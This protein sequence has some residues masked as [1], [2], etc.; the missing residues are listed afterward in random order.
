MSEVTPEKRAILK[1]TPSNPHLA[2]EDEQMKSVFKKVTFKEERPSRSVQVSLAGKPDSGRLHP[3]QPE[4][5]SSCGVNGFCRSF[6]PFVA[7]EY[8]IL[9]NYRSNRQVDKKLPEK[10]KV[11]AVV[12]ECGWVKTGWP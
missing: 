3:K 2:Q 7:E 6:R 1:N 4:R 11:E 9:R 8:E 10:D 5:C 12:Q